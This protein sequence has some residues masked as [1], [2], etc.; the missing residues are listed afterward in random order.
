[1]PSWHDEPVTRPL[2]VVVPAG[3]VSAPASSG[4]TVR[5]RGD[6]GGMV[7]TE[8]RCPVHGRF[9]LLVLRS[10]VPDAMACPTSAGEDATCGERSP[11]SPSTVGIG[12]APGE[13]TC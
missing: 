11:W 3:A 4:F 12:F 8:Y 5:R 10:D 1:M 2:I 13:V 7:A 9:T 6:V